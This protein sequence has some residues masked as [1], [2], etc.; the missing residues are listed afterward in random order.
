MRTSTLFVAAVILACAFVI[1]GCGRSDRE[2]TVSGQAGAKL[3]IIA[4]A[5][6]TITR[7]G[8]AEVKMVI[9][10][11]GIKDPVSISFQELPTGVTVA[12]AD[13]KIVGLEGTYTLKAADDAQLVANHHAHVKATGTGNISATVDLVITVVEKQ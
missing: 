1:I 8:T 6:V 5:P 3:T 2:S 11:D 9:T 4:P 12:A 10:R 7:G 13:T